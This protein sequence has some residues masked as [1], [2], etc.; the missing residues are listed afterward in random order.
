LTLDRTGV[1]QAQA[2]TSRQQSP[3]NP[4]Q[5]RIRSQRVWCRTKASTGLR[6]YGQHCRRTFLPPDRV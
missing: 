6:R 3:V 4:D 5:T 1:A 2:P